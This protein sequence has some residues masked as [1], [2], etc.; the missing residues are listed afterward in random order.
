MFIKAEFDK[1]GAQIVVVSFGS[2]DAAIQWRQDTS[3]PYPILLD[4]KRQ[5]RQ[6]SS[7]SVIT[8]LKLAV[9][10]KF[11]SKTCWNIFHLCCHLLASRKLVAIVCT[12]VSDSTKAS[13]FW[14]SLQLTLSGTYASVSIHY[15]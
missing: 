3:C 14:L 5:V 2:R 7:I 8:S 9:K 4:A 11:Y 10:S 15:L 12:T 1:A 13:K 6:F